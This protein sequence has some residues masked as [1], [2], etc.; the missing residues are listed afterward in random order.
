MF[1]RGVGVLNGFV[2]GA[3]VT[4]TCVGAGEF[5]ATKLDECSLR[6]DICGVKVEAG[7]AAI[8]VDDLCFWVGRYSVFHFV[9]EVTGI[10]VVWWSGGVDGCGGGGDGGG[11]GGGGGGK[12]LQNAWLVE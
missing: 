11:G 7:D 4:T 6:W 9:K 12:P 8:A 3:D 1:A 5:F 2:A 10:F